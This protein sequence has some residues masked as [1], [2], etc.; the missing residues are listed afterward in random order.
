MRRAYRAK[1]TLQKFKKFFHA[2]PKLETRELKLTGHMA[3]VVAGGGQPI[4]AALG[5]L[6]SLGLREIAPI[7]HHD[8][9]LHPAGEGLEQLAIIDRGGG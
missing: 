8:P 1:G 7:A 9:V 2:M 4:H 5:Q 6:L 3:H